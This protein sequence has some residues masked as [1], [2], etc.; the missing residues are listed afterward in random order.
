[1]R[2]YHFDVRARF[3]F[4]Q[5]KTKTAKKKPTMKNFNSDL[6]SASCFESNRVF[7]DFCA[8]QVLFLEPLVLKRGGGGPRD[9]GS[10]PLTEPHYFA[11]VGWRLLGAGADRI[12]QLLPLSSKSGPGRTLIPQGSRYGHSSWTQPDCFVPG[13][14]CLWEAGLSV[15]RAAARLDR[16]LQRRP[17]GRWQ[18]RNGIY[19]GALQNLI[20]AIGGTQLSNGGA[21]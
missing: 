17:D 2:A 20:R 10:Y 18:R 15:L 5:H 16:S 3:R 14:P 7:P 8:G 19:S 6:S 4:K 13:P 11:L 9:T 12:C 21:A 1:V